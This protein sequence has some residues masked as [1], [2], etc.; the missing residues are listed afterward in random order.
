MTRKN[1]FNTVTFLAIL[2]GLIF[3]GFIVAV[4]LYVKNFYD[5]IVYM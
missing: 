4:I 2:A 3:S 1:K 5:A